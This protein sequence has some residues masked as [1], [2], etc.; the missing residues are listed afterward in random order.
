MNKNQNGITIISLAVTI[1]VLIILAGIS[2]RAITGDNS[3]IREAENSNT[4]AQRE[5][6]LE[7]IEADIYTEK[8]KKGRNLTKSEAESIIEK[9][10]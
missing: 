8:I 2:I 7:K 6:I 10:R 4:K 9:Q 5:S 1:A 3:V